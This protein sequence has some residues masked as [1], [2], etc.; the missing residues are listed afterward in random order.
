MVMEIKKN[1]IKLDNIRKV[2]GVSLRTLAG[3]I[4]TF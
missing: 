1:R 3:T 4:F 2:R